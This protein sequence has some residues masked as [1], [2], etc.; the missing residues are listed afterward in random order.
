MAGAMARACGAHLRTWRP[1]TLAYPGLV[2]LAG[3]ALAD[4][5]SSGGSPSGGSPVGGGAS[6]VQLLVAW[7]APTLSWLAAHYLGDYFDRHLDAISKPQRPIP[8]GQ[9][10]PRT[11]VVCGVLCA[12]AAAFVTVLA[13]WR[14]LLLVAGAMA[15][16]VAYSLVLKGRG[17]SGNAIRGVLTALTVV[18][19]AMTAS[20]DPPW[21]AVVPFAL[22]FLAHDAASNLVG[23]L[24]DVEGDRSGGYRTLPV[25]RGLRVA[26]RTAA[27]LYLG[28]IAV[29]AL[30][31]PL[32]PADPVGFA[33]LLVL[34]AVCGGF[35]FSLVLRRELT[36]T[37]ALALRAHEV[38]VVERLV[39]AGAVMAGGWGAA[40][41]G[42][43]TGP[44]LVVSLLTQARMRRRHEFPPDSG[45]TADAELPPG[46]RNLDA[47][48]SF[49]DGPSHGNPPP[50]PTDSRTADRHGRAL[51]TVPDP[52]G[53]EQARTERSRTERSRT[54]RSG[55]A[56]SRTTASCTEQ[57][58][59]EQAPTEQPGTAP[60]RTTPSRTE[61][62]PT[63]QSGTA[64][65]RTAPPRTA[66]S[67]AAPS[68]TAPSGA[69]RRKD[70]ATP[71]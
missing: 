32:V 55:A 58:R 52:P 46:V 37:P 20:A 10:S 23:T 39:L 48:G 21:Q 15:G 36:V 27:L 17:L 43:V 14:A 1:Y 13:N 45:F 60:S 67:R 19:G 6:G 4:G 64:P 34:A 40:V 22:V 41:A 33:A 5:S 9:L 44:L 50:T 25:L 28:A 61:Q 71:C 66:P 53:T 7:A 3:A 42:A 31:V 12:L 49:P 56:P 24:R 62:A 29:A 69:A 2:G 16:I 70:D 38:L 54:E 68:R 8:S 63:Q 35:A 30:S 51:R 11:A 47:E 26:A 65:S 57:A 59:S 18:Y